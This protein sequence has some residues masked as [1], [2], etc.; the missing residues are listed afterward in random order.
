MEY[1]F[2]NMW[3]LLMMARKNWLRSVASTNENTAIYGLKE[4]P[5]RDQESLNL[6]LG[7]LDRDSIIRKINKDHK[8]VNFL[9]NKNLKK[10]KEYIHYKE[11]VKLKVVVET[12]YS[13]LT[14]GVNKHTIV[15]FDETQINKDESKI[16]IITL[17]SSSKEVRIDDYNTV[18]KVLLKEGVKESPTGDVYAVQGV[19]STIVP[20]NDVNEYIK[21]A[22]LN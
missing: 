11:A 5:L 6:R 15:L 20:H 16:S 13:T 18:G 19:I 7:K 2:I 1:N 3:I 10:H 21:T 12:R 8:Q 9:M 17:G 22:T 4:M 14:F